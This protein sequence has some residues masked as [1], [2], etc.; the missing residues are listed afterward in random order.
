MVM[1]MGM[2]R[3]NTVNRVNAGKADWLSLAKLD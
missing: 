1:V 3:G 2:N